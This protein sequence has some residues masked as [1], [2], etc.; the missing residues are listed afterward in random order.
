M[1]LML[2][3]FRAHPWQSLITV[4]SLLLS[5]IAEG[6]GLSALL[7]LLN[8]ALNQGT[9]HVQ[10]GGQ[11]PAGD[12]EQTVID[13]MAQIGLSPTIG[14]L[15]SVIVV[16][17]ALKTV[18]LLIATR[19]VGYTAAR[20]TTDLRLQLLHAILRSKWEFFLSQPLGKL[21][22]S[23]ATE[24]NR[25]SSAFVGGITLI[26]YVI[27]AF[28]YGSV[29]IAV[30]W[31]ATLVSLG[32]GVLIVA[33]SHSLVRMARKAGKKQTRL[34]KSLLIQLNDTLQSVKPLKAMAREHLA[35]SSLRAK[36]NRL[37]STLQKQ[38]LSAAVLN[39]VQELLFTIVIALG[40]YLALVRFDMP[41]PTVMILVVALGRML[42]QF[43]KVQ[44]QYQKMMTLESAFWSMKETIDT[45]RN[46]E[47]HLGHGTMPPPLKSGIRMQEVSFAYGENQVLNKLSLDIPGGSLTTLTGPSGAGK[48]TI[49]DLIIGLLK[50]QSGE[51]L[52]DNMP[53]GSLEL[54]EWRRMI[55]YVPQET[56]LLHDSIL[57]NVTLGD[58]EYSDRDAEAALR[59]AGAWEFVAA[60]PQGIH[61]VVGERGGRLSGGQ[62]QRV[63]IA[64]ALV[65][66]PKLL[67]LDEATS[68]LD[69]A[70]E[71][72]I[73]RSIEELRGGQ[74][75]ILA[76]SHQKRL[77]DAADHVYRL[78]DGQALL[79]DRQEPVPE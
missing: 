19:Q 27:Y 21:S 71:A 12:F 38:V 73:A 36:T 55:G 59:A 79:V 24:A 77:V 43:G 33:L 29:A 15:L 11:G 46:A 60:L 70:S 61:S 62:R 74:L 2:F 28:I 69:P 56:I 66:R 76:I 52:I 58:P 4:I 64:R 47:E 54:R 26:T 49:I 6:V 10:D 5:G 41:M 13:L 30:S 16:A 39:S 9:R 63:V 72:A 20:V 17:V 51:I 14:A 18:L 1:Q 78:Q 34:L 8:L 50:Q 22:N 42:N 23:L 67:I 7:P 3:F 65:H 48:T 40:M 53:L 37:N 44:K 25:S 68:A 31:K 32:V 57:H 35:D 75:T 45:A